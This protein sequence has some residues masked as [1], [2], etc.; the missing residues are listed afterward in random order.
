MRQYTLPPLYAPSQTST[1]PASAASNSSPNSGYNTIYAAPPCPVPTHC[2]AARALGVLASLVTFD[3]ALQGTHQQSPGRT[4]DRPL[5]GPLHALVYFIEAPRYRHRG[6]AV[7]DVDADDDEPQ[8]AHAAL[9]ALLGLSRVPGYIVALLHAGLRGGVGGGVDVATW[10][11]RAPA[12][13]AVLR[14]L[15]AVGDDT[16]GCRGVLVH[17]IRPVVPGVE[18]WLRSGNPSSRRAEEG[19]GTETLLALVRRL[20]P[21]RLELLRLADATQFEPTVETA[22]ALCDG[23]MYL[24]LQDAL[25]L[26]EM[27]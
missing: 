5:L 8:P 1:R 26:L 16:R 23:V 25:G 9:A 20:E 2:A 17:P 15:R 6:S 19:G 24:L 21:A 4:A 7:E 22:H 11:G 10:M 13:G 12:Y 3:R 27:E 18:A 14:V